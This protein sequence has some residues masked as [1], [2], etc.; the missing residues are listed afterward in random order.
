MRRFTVSLPEETYE[1]VRRQAQ[2][3]T[4]PST[5]QQMV[6]YAV[7]ALLETGVTSGDSAAE[8]TT[9]AAAAEVVNG[10]DVL[11]FSVRDV[12]YGIPVESVET[13]AAGLDIHHVPTIGG[14][15]L[16]MASFRG[17]LTEVHDGGTVLQDEPLEELHPQ[18]LAI[19]AGGRRVLVTVSSV[20]GLVPAEEVQW[21]VRPATSPEWVSALAWSETRVIAVIDPAGF[22]L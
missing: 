14:S 15:L 11:V 2:H 6:R 18:L 8:S 10:V 9:P 20:S 4:P 13:V 5:L 19:P 3:A 7:E 22:R 16:G 1:A 21:A 17:T 12:T